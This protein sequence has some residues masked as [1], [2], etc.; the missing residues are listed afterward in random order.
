MNECLCRVNRT[1]YNDTYTG[2]EEEERDLLF[3]CPVQPSAAH[4]QGS[5]HQLSILYI[6]GECIINHLWQAGAT[7]L[8][9]RQCI[10]VATHFAEVPT[11]HSLDRTDEP[12]W[13]IHA[14]S[15]SH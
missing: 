4:T 3:H 13:I 2:F 7:Q 11:V 10:M 15:L 12:A 1:V 9:V 14:G 8:M 6:V 5:L